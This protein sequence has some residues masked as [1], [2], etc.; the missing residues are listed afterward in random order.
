MDVEAC[1]VKMGT[2]KSRDEDLEAFLRRPGSIIPRPQ[3]DL[4]K[5]NRRDLERRSEHEQ[6][7]PGDSGR[8]LKKNSRASAAVA[9]TRR[10]ILYPTIGSVQRASSFPSHCALIICRGRLFT[11]VTTASAPPCP[12]HTFSHRTYSNFLLHGP[13]SH[14]QDRSTKISIVSPKKMYPELAIFSLS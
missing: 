4:D 12:V 2:Q 10:G 8:D 3:G 11:P 14:I 5:F 7:K 13:L 1:R 6:S 9:T